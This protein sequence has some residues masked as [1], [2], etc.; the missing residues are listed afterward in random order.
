M[1]IETEETKHLPHYVCYITLPNGDPITT[2]SQ[3]HLRAVN[4]ADAE[5]VA[6]SALD[7]ADIQYQFVEDLKHEIPEN[8]P[9]IAPLWSWV[10]RT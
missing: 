1:M 4:R 9:A 8:E 5:K 6:R 10:P 3:I 2:L 7:D